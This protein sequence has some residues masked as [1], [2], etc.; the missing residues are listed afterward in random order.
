MVKEH[1][2]VEKV[3]GISM[4]CSMPGWGDMLAKLPRKAACFVLET[5]DAASRLLPCMS[6][7]LVVRC[8]PKTQSLVSRD[9]VNS[10]VHLEL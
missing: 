9:W 6:D 7:V 2:N 8:V 5:L 4:L 3:T 10:T 1:M